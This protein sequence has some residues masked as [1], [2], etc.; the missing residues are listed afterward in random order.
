LAGASTPNVLPVAQALRP[1][2][3]G[4][5]H[6]RFPG[7]IKDGVTFGVVLDQIKSA[8]AGHPLAALQPQLP[9]LAALNDFVGQFHHDTAGIVLRD[10]V[11]DS[12]LH[13]FAKQ[14]ML[15]VQMGTT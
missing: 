6:R 14:A 5:L 10:N 3:E 9:A 15:F 1:L 12:E 11:A 8:A 7:L 2:V 4:S 13:P